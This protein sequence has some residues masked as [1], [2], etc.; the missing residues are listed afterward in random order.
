MTPMNSLY[1]LDEIQNRAWNMGGDEPSIHVVAGTIHDNPSLTEEGKRQIMSGWDA[2]E[3]EAREKGYFLHLAGRVFPEFS[4][5][6]EYDEAQFD[7]LRIPGDDGRPTD[8]ASDAPVACII[9]PH[10]RRRWVILW[11]ALDREEN[12]WVVR[13]WP[14]DEKLVNQPID[15]GPDGVFLYMAKVIES[16]EKALP[17]GSERVLWRE[18]DPNM[19]QSPASGSGYDTVL[20]ALRGAGQQIGLPL[21]FRA[22]VS[23]SVDQ[24]IAVLRN[25]LAF[26]ASQPVAFD[27][28]P[29]LRVSSRCRLTIWS[30]RNYVW[31]NWP[32][33]TRAPREKTK[34]IGKDAVDALRYF[35]MRN[36][37]WRDWKHR[38]GAIAAQI[39]RKAERLIGSG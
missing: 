29:A 12:A 1:V 7:P 18:M 16:V 35:A 21:A 9:D 20:R 2:S 27:N 10:G 39:Q 23:D 26:D 8:V 31:E 24:G 5:A 14:N 19:G 6:H 32:D 3:R 30:L 17:G 4:E 38:G 28:M 36:P 15:Y 34:E 22:D 25:R 13:E 33:E 11:I 37:K